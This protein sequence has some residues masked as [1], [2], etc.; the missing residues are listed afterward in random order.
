MKQPFAER[1]A[2]TGEFEPIDLA[3]ADF[4]L[5]FAHA[6]ECEE[7]YLAALF[8]SRA[9]RLSHSCCP[10]RELAGTLFPEIPAEGQR[11]FR[12]PGCDAWLERLSAP[13]LAATVSRYPACRDAGFP[14]PLAIDG[15]GRLYLQRY[16]VYELQVAQAVMLRARRPEHPPEL[17]PGAFDELFINYRSGAATGRP[18]FQRLAA[19]AA[20]SRDFTVISGGP[21][22]GKT[23]VVAAL[24]ALEFARAPELRVALCAPTG[25]AQAR[26]GEALREDGLKIG[27]AEAI[28]RRIL[29][30]APSTI[31]RLIGS[32]PLTH[33]TKYHA[34]N[35]LPFDLVIVDESSMVSLPLMARLMRALAPETRL[36]LLG[37]PNQLAS[38]ESGA[39]LADICD[40]GKCNAFSGAIREAYLRQSPGVFLAEPDDARPLTGALAELTHNFRFDTA[41]A[42]GEVSS[43]IKLL[44][45]GAT[46][47]KIKELT[48][49]IHHQQNDDFRTIAVTRDQLSARLRQELARE[50][51]GKR[52]CF[53]RLAELAEAGT[54][55]A[56]TEAFGLLNAFKV[57]AA[58]RRGPFGVE[59]LN[60]IIRELFHWKSDDTPGMPVMILANDRL[61]G[62]S[63]GDI[64]LFWKDLAG[65]GAPRIYFPGF[66]RS[67]LAAEL[68]E[69]EPVFAMT[70]HKSQG[71]GFSRALLV[72]PD[73]DSPVLTREL[74][75]TGI[76]RASKEVVLWSTPAVTRLMLE[77]RTR[78]ASGLQARLAEAQEL[79]SGRRFSVT[80]I[81]KS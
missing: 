34:G 62:L 42:I 9:V 30:L 66:E 64:G 51:P 27:T 48:D 25:K 32:A 53:L 43:A 14:T 67:F 12:L 13:A 57:L 24:L 72:L 35:P 17:L 71:S 45:D 15:A 2:A 74:L 79:H 47:E 56:L 22:T 61:T 10:L 44:Q 81:L 33:R 46:P 78:R 7:L 75:Y 63:N 77:R 20:A 76:T 6:P 26:L 36:I 69:H 11:Q 68:P 19:L 41:P 23:T 59:E 60:R 39:V 31:D 4:M 3:F 38:V 54:A 58:V 80:T 73:G 40:S 37:D 52:G 1:C 21:G 65:S 49:F 28:R 55:E 8:A 16:L 18:D 5:R 29:E 50:L 70:I